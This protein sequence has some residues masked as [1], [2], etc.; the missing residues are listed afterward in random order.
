MSNSMSERILATYHIETAGEV[1]RVAEIMAG[2]QS[3]GTFVKVPGETPELLARHGA[4]VVGI[5][6]LEAVETPSLPGAQA[7][8]SGQAYQRARVTLSFPLENIG[9]SLTT[10]FTTVAGNLFELHPLA[11]IR[12]LD[13]TIPAAFGEKYP[14]PQF[15]IE[16]TRT[17]AGVQARPLIG[18]I[19][20]PS[21]GLS[22]EATAELVAVLCEAGL[23]FIKDDELQTNSPHSPLAERVA[24][25]MRVINAHAERTGKKVMVAFN[26]TG[27]LED[28][29]RGHDVVLAHG[30][31][32]IMVNMLAVGLAG[33]IELRRHSQL[34]IHGHRA[35]WGALSRHPQL[36][37]DYRAFQ[38]FFR[39]A[40]VD[41]LHVNGLRNKFCESDASV[42]AS[43]QECL[44][45]LPG[46]DYRVMPVFSSG[47]TAAQAPDTYAALDSVDLMFLAGGG[48][49]AHPAGAAAGV[50]SL[51]QAWEAA[52]Q[53]IPLTTYA[54][55]HPELQQALQRFGH[56]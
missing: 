23:D 3:A 10:L 20:K 6:P 11:G 42:V 15:G 49:M 27:D 44:T 26:V 1:T 12:L 19:I 17:L 24:A 37:L 50:R 39:V 56:A 55:T 16:G 30:G 29:K 2:E 13:V 47:Q 40:G 41:H 31:T 48:L 9:L 54:Q 4:R 5:T 8:A 52:L 36:G 34:P 28:M 22:P 25:V 7:A 53:H 38:K 32:C 45:P 51:Q 35:G 21:V 14:G 43:A 18:T 46:L 33:V